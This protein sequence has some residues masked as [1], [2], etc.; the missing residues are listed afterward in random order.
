MLAASAA[1]GTARA[2]AQAP[3][4]DAVLAANASVLPE[5]AGAG[6]NHYPMAA[7]TLDALGHAER[8]DDAWRTGAAGYAGEAGRVGPIADVQAALGD[9]GRYGDW[10]DHFEGE[11][12]RRPWRAVASEWSARLAPG[13]CAAVFHGA[14]RSAHAVRALRREESE[15]RRAELAAALAY[16]AAR[17]TELPAADPPLELATPLEALPHPW[18]DENDDV[19]FDEV[20]AR[21]ARAAI[22]PRVTG[23]A[24]AAPAGPAFDALIRE[25]SAA[26]LEMLVL[27]RQRLWLLHTVTG[28]AA[29]ALLAEDLDAPAAG[30]LAA[31]SRQAVVAFHVAFG[32]PYTPFAHVREAT[33]PWPE[34]LE[35]ACASGSVHTIKLVE[36]LHRQ[37]DVD[38]PLMRSVAAQWFEW[39]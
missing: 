38:D 22:A 27:E 30:A 24:L 20:H 37:R 34:M 15:A 18:L 36:V 12:E 11:L 33:A 21:L 23:E 16:W 31:W 25:A 26:F 14:I 9:W 17:Y 35:R 1:R 8:I 7:E 2:A 13:V 5:R 39:T 3:T 10:L 6:A 28:P 32:A 19:P 29:A 4:L